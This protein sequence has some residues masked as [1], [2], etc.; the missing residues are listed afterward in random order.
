MLDRT[1]CP[2]C[3]GTLRYEEDDGGRYSLPPEWVCLQ[4]GWRRAY[5]PRQ[6]ERT[7]ALVADVR[8]EV[9]A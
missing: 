5:T 6:F 4:C 7:F 3:H 9:P 1:R 8:V 2:K